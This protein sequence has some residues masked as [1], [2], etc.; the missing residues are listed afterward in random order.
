MVGLLAETRDRLLTLTG[1]GRLGKTR[2]ALQAAAELVR[3]RSRDGVCWV[4]LSGAQRAGARR[5]RR[6]RRHSARAGEL[7]EHLGR[8]ASCCSCSTTSSSSSRPR[9][10]SASC[11]R[12][13]EPEAARDEPRAAARSR[14]ARVPGA[15][16]RRAGGGRRSSL[17][18]RARSSGFEPTSTCCRSAAASTDL[19]LALELAAARVKALSTAADPRAPRAAAAAAHR[20]RARRAR[21]AADPAGGDRLELR[22]A[23]ARGAGLFARLAVFAGGFTLEAAE[24][25]A[26]GD[27]DTLQSLVEK[28]LVRFGERALLAARDDPRIR[29]RAA[30]ETDGWEEAPAA[31]STSSLRWRARRTRRPKVGTGGGRSS[32]SR[33][34]EPE[35]GHR[36]RGCGRRPPA[37][38]RADGAPRELLGRDRPARRRPPL[39][40]AAGAE[41]ELPEKLRARA[42]RCEPGPCSSAANTSARTTRTKRASRSSARSATT[43]A[44]LS[45]SSTGW[46]SARWRSATPDEA[47]RILDESLRSYH[48]AGSEGGGGQQTTGG[49]GD[50][51]GEEGDYETA[52]E[53]F[54]RG[55]E[56]AELARFPWWRVAML[57]GLAE[58]LLELGR[59]DQAEPVMRQH[60]P[61]AREIGDR[62]SSLHGL[63]VFAWLAASRGDESRAGLLWAGSR[64]RSGAHR[65]GSGSSS[66]TITSGR[67]SA[68]AGR[69]SRGQGSA[70]APS[71]SKLRWT[72]RSRS[73]RDIGRS[74]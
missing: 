27:V 21:A 5:P 51:G 28:S 62:Q 61:L 49:L 53:L 48:R 55:A 11:S 7:A 38:D 37:R 72:R 1:A 18:A 74:L 64:P 23:H 59:G 42:L 15:A 6:S 43:R 19:P 39:R 41:D 56:L 66:A 63:V 2:L 22:A 58:C 20:R 71:R 36:G 46:R 60:L 45:S 13:P 29:A 31:T 9:P 50:W 65:W 16:A 8:A 67:C 69:S 44:L 47:R 33:R 12:V 32:C 52:I 35:D 26:G 25:V 70:V 57:S 10:S 17:T 3:R 68:R 30:Q 34:R 40:G 73:R 4:P 24:Q 54:T 14:R